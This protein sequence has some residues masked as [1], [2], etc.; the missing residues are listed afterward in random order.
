MIN[1]DDRNDIKEIELSL[2]EIIDVLKNAKVFII[3]ATL[4]ITLLGSL[5]SSQQPL[6]Y[7]SSAIVEVGS[8]E[9][10]D[11]NNLTNNKLIEN[12]DNL[13]KELKVHFLYKR[14]QYSHNLVFKALENRLLEISITSS[15]PAHNEEKLSEILKFIESRHSNLIV[16]KNPNTF[17]LDNNAKKVDSI[18]NKIAALKSTLYTE[19]LSKLELYKNHLSKI[20]SEEDRIEREIKLTTKII[21]DEENNFNLI[22]N[23]PDLIKVRVSQYPTFEQ[24]IYNY[25]ILI[26]GLESRLLESEFE[27][28]KLLDEKNDLENLIKLL[29]SGDIDHKNTEVLRL[30]D[31]KIEAEKI[32]ESI[33]ELKINK[34]MVIKENQPTQINQ[35]TN[36][37]ILLLSFVFGLLV[38]IVIT[39]IRY[40]VLK[41]YNDN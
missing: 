5:Y 11:N 8:F 21:D 3:S 14:A 32:L 18:T 38:S 4:I 31:Q 29:E 35:A 1:S 2:K 12:L 23:E 33:R 26:L 15:S 6:K 39:F 20:E 25:K 19:T 13:I 16:I 17:H 27:K 9:I 28:N 22:A 7:Q 36:R 41:A 10:F 30:I 24:T 40:F 37:M 34:T